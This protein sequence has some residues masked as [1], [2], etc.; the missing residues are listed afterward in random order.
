MSKT[1]KEQESA[2]SA[3][4]QMIKDRLSEEVYDA[5][6][7]A[8]GEMSYA[9]AARIIAARHGQIAGFLEDALHE[10]VHSIGN[11]DRYASQQIKTL[12]VREY[13]HGYTGAKPVEEQL[14]ILKRDHA[15][16]AIKGKFAF[17][18]EQQV[19]LQRMDPSHLEGIFL[20]PPYHM[21]DEAGYLPAIEKLL[22]NFWNINTLPFHLRGL[23]ETSA[24]VHR[25]KDEW[26]RQGSGNITLVW[27]Q[28]GALYAGKS[29]LRADELMLAPEEGGMGVYGFLSMLT[30]HPER[31]AQSTDPTVIC[32]GDEIPIAGSLARESKVPTISS[33]GN[34]L[35][36]DVARW[37]EF[38]VEMMVA[39]LLIPNKVD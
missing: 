14:E 39:S 17:T 1:M 2:T 20:L 19:L 30:M 18:E 9:E 12:G 35:R 7:H 21:V 6:A 5:F 38:S 8:V 3:Q 32:S 13:G 24:K 34:S 23:E 36:F 22:A 4:R 25:L 26:K 10:A 27:A 28:L 15:K 16:W 29:A 33:F 37:D 31:L 11:P